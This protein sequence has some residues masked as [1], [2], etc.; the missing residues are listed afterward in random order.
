MIT[1]I[2]HFLPFRTKPQICILSPIFN[3]MRILHFHRNNGDLESIN[4]VLGC[5]VIF[6]HY[7]NTPEDLELF[8]ESESEKNA[9]ILDAFFYTANWFREVICAFASQREVNIRSKVL[10]RLSNLISMEATIRNMLSVLPSSYCPPKCHFMTMETNPVD[11]K[12][13]KPVKEAKDKK[14]PNDSIPNNSN[15]MANRTQNNTL[16]NL[17]QTTKCDE[18]KGPGSGFYGP[19]EVYRQLDPDV[20]LLLQESLCTIYPLPK[21]KLG[22]SLGLAEYKFILEDLILKLE[23]VTGLKKCTG[24]QKEQ[25]IIS[26]V[27]LIYDIKQFLPR[28]MYF[29]EQ[30]SAAIQKNQEFGQEESTDKFLYTDEMGQLKRSFGLTLRLM[31]ALFSW[32]G[33]HQEKHEELLKSKKFCDRIG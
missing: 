16:A 31:A 2:N 7:S 33:F 17:L 28:I 25:F 20:M 9:L 6:P 10:L 26:P 3:L 29:F 32:Q 30:I 21:E 15:L 19:K 5:P 12:K 11:M 22:V 23:S 18:K 13:P 27:A 1:I 4:A 24:F 8:D 14:K